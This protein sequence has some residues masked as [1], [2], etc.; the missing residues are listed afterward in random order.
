MSAKIYPLIY[1]GM[2]VSLQTGLGLLMEKR[3]WNGISIQQPIKTVTE[4]IVEL[5]WGVHF[6]NTLKP[7]WLKVAYI[8]SNP[9][10]KSLMPVCVNIRDVVNP[11]ETEQRYIAEF[12]VPGDTIILY[13]WESKGKPLTSANAVVV[14]G[15]RLHNLEAVLN[16]QAQLPTSPRKF[17]DRR[18]LRSANGRNRL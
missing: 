11:I 6:N 17:G 14:L 13:W 10:D 2:A 3:L 12:W 5:P 1:Q 9:N 15:K 4:G 18:G 16:S 8:G 7:A